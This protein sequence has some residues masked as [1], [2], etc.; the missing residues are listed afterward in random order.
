MTPELWRRE[1]GFETAI[2]ERGQKFYKRKPDPCDLPDLLG[3]LAHSSSVMSTMRTTTGGV[4]HLAAVVGT[5]TIAM[6]Q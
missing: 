2:R 4:S 6:L 5:A 1:S 3:R